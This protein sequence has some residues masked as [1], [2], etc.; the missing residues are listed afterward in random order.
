MIRANPEV[1]Q[2][3]ATRLETLIESEQIGH[4]RRQGRWQRASWT[5]SAGV[6]AVA[7]AIVVVFFVPLPHASLFHNLVA[8]A[9]VGTPTKPITN[10]PVVDLSAT[11]AGW[12]PVDYGEAQ[13]SVPP[14]W[15]VLY[16]WSGCVSGPPVGVVYFNRTDGFCSAKGIPKG[17]TT[18]RMLSLTDKQYQPP[19]SY[20]QR[21]VV[22]GIPVYELYSFSPIPNEGSYLVPSLG[23][24]IESKG[25]LTKRVLDTLTRSPRTVVLASGPATT[26]PPSWW[27][28]TFAGLRLPVPVGWRVQSTTAWNSCGGAVWEAVILDTDKTYQELFCPAPVLLAVPPSDGLRVDAGVRRPTG[29][30]SPGGTCRHI[31]GLTVCPSRTP[32]YSVLLLKV[33]VPGRSKPVY[34]SIGLA[35]NGLVARTIL[36]SLRAA[37]PSRTTAK[38]TGI[39]TGVVQACAGVQVPAGEIIHVKVSLYS[40]SKRV[41]SETVVSG[42]KYR[43]SVSPGTYRLTGWWGSKGVTVRA[44]RSVTVNFWNPCI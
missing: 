17:E 24:E 10:L 41:A 3:L 6:I 30:F 31:G 28:V 11:P 34:V 14:T 43:F 5:H 23:V 22:N 27:S 26:V 40:G 33:T 19:A 35:G 29:S 32:G 20:G 8:P 7:A 12:V 38:P 21:Q 15:W 44:G 13:I 37:S 16:N 1:R 18:I 36:Y 2:R 9:K 39:V 4:K 42:T 25:P